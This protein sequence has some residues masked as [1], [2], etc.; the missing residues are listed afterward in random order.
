MRSTLY[1]RVRRG[2]IGRFGHCTIHGTAFQIAC[3]RS[4]WFLSEG[5]ANCTVALQVAMGP[6]PLQ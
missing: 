6:S 3:V 5:Q 4:T 1:L 2:S